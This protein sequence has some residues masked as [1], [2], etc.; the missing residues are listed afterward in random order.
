MLNQVKEIAITPFTFAYLQENKEKIKAL[1]E[2]LKEKEYSS[3][4]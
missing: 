3:K 2:Y 4:N 1:L